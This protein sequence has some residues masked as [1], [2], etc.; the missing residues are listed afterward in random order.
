MRK[1]W[2]LPLFT[3]MVL[4]FLMPSYS[5]GAPQSEMK[6]RRWAVVVG[7]D[8]YM[9]EVTPLSCAEA[10][11]LRFS[12]ALVESSGFDEKNVFTLLSSAKGNQIPTT[13][14][15]I[16]RI[17]YIKSNATPDDLFIFF[18]SGH[19]MDM[20]RKSYLLTY[21]ADPYSKDTLEVSSLKVS[22]LSRILRDMPAQRILLFVDAC[23]NDPRGG[24]GDI[25]N[26]M[27]EDQSKG[28]VI[29][30]QDTAQPQSDG[31]FSM[32]FFSCR[33]GQRSYE[34]S[35]QGMG[36]FTY[37]LVKALRGDKGACDPGGKV[38]LGSLKRYLGTEVPE[39]VKRERGA[40]MLQEPWCKGDASATS[41]DFML[42]WVKHPSVSPEKHPPVVPEKPPIK[43]PEKPQPA[44]PVE[45]GMTPVFVDHFDGQTPSSSMLSSIFYGNQR[46]NAR[47]GVSWVPG[48]KGKA[49]HLDGLSSYAG[50]PC[51]LLNPAEGSIRF[52]FKPDPDIYRLYTVRQGAWRDFGNAAPPFSGSLIDTA[53]WKEAFPG[54]FHITINF[55]GQ[56]N[57]ATSS[58]SSGLWSGK[59]WSTMDCA[60]PAAF[61][62]SEREWYDMLFTWSARDGKAKLYMNG[63][64]L[65]EYPCKTL[66]NTD[67]NFFIGQSPWKREGIDYWP[68]G[69][70]SMKGSYDEL[71]IF[72]RALQPSQVPSR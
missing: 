1:K 27:T 61:R 53:G 7:I 57:G 43:L 35:E 16:K 4:I 28:L 45:Q 51:R 2:L 23:R 59:E 46:I 20:D 17:S 72:D 71:M 52:F 62:W 63:A 33:V 56:G 26:P 21:E 15:I 31:A 37:H 42:S 36:F 25:S 65:K 54:S 39:A 12:K 70:H 29:K 60:L 5:S 55:N 48:L 47:A 69:P 50:Y 41:D 58:L 24:K 30:K 10:D 44:P 14:N 9:N 64:L 68:Y 6:G 22:E 40:A 67:E 13:S 18:F 19:G 34:W 3:V 66:L 49:L 32:T 8:H 11:A 38:T